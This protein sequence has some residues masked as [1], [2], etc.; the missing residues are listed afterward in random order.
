MKNDTNNIFIILQSSIQLNLHT[1]ALKKMKNMRVQ[2]S[3]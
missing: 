3:V 2:S 1:C